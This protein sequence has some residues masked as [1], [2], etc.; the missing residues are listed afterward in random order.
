MSGT[1]V[2]DPRRL[3]W[4]WPERARLHTML[5]DEAVWAGY[6]KAAASVGLQLDVISV[7]DVDVVATPRDPAVFV[8]GQRVDP[9]QALFHGKL[10][11]WPMFAPDVWRSLATFEAIRAAGYCTL[12][13]SEL[14]LISNDKAATLL[15][16]RGVDE[17][18]LPT[19]SLPTR[20][21]TRLRVR[22]REA[23]IGYPVV[24]KPASWGSGMGV[25]TA[26]DEGEL[27]TALRLSS[28]AELT[29]VVQPLLV[30]AGGAELADLRLYCVDGQV[31][32][33][34]RRTPAEGGT[35]ANVTAGGNGELI[36]PPADL[37]HRA[38][39][40]AR[41]LDTPWLGVDFLC[42]GDVGQLSE[43]EIDACIGPVTSCL[44]GMDDILARRFQAY[45]DRFDRWT[46]DR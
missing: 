11:T 34:L 38:E 25:V 24:V 21:L 14:N 12:I 46:A 4:F 6:R 15:H 22:L 26:R 31:V 33:A 18:W 43:V 5:G 40:V 32:G 10:Y 3:F 30:P 19:L 20:G 13:R 9:E 2:Q 16:L 42:V 29:M 7:D 41:L 44:P 1:P 37:A 35:V 8:R 36:E 45:R 17:Q 39:A 23:G 28:A 27:L